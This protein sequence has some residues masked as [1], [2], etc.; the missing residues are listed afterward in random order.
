MPNLL[1]V[2]LRFCPCF[3]CQSNIFNLCLALGEASTSLATRA[4][5][6]ARLVDASPK[7]RQRLKIL[8][9]HQ[10]QGQN[11]SLTARRF[12]IQRL[13]L[14][15]WIKRAKIAGVAGLN[16]RSHRPRHLRTMVT[17][18]KTIMAIVALRKQYTAW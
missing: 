1:A 10:K 18:W 6:V 11:L 2:R 16:D 3:W 17:P 4:A 8:D 15:R 12:G 14:R 9:W 5:L 13:T 7:A